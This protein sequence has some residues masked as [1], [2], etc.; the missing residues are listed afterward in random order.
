M[1]YILRSSEAFGGPLL[2]SAVYIYVSI[3]GWAYT[4]DDVLM[5][6]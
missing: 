3:E 6:Y 1:A 4:D 2:Q 5:M